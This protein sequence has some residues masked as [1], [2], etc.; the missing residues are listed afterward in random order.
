LVVIDCYV[1]VNPGSFKAHIIGGVVH[2]L[3]ATHYDRQT[4]INGAAQAKN[5]RQS[6]M[7]RLDEM[8]QVAVQIMPNPATANRSVCIG[9]VE[10]LGVPTLAP[11]LANA[12]SLLTGKRVCALPFFPNATMGSL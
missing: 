6:R 10:E 4:F 12:H 1:S 8:P 3:N 7:I 9:G 2:G 5:F 11:A